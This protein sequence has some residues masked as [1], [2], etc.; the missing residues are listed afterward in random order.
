MRAWG[1]DSFREKNCFH[2]IAT[3]LFVS[4]HTPGFR[5]S[6]IVLKRGLSADKSLW[7]WRQS[8]ISGT[9]ERKSGSV[10]LLDE[11]RKEVAPWNFREG[12]PAKWE[13]PHFRAEGN[14]VAIETLEIVHEGFDWV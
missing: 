6:P 11:A 8:V 4:F 10:V 3:V 13:G 9:I 2:R 14:E 12:W 7:K 5:Y 1:P